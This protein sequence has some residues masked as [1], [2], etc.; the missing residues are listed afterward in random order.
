MSFEAL[1][2]KVKQAETAL[3]AQERQAAADW[4]Q[5]KASG[6]A[7]GRRAASSSPGWS[8]G[9]LVGRSNRRK[10]AAQRRRPLQL[11]STLAGL[12]A[13]GSAQAAA[14]EA[15]QAADTAQQTAAAVAP[16]AAHRPPPRDPQP[17]HDAESL[18]EA[19][20]VTTSS[21][22]SA[23][24]AGEPSPD[25]AD[26]SHAAARRRPTTAA[27]ATASARVGRVAGAGHARGRLHAVGRAGPDPAGAAGDVLRA[28]RQPDHPPAAAAV[29]AALRRR[30]AGAGAA[31]SSGTV[32]LGSNWSTPAGEWV[33]QVPRADARPRAE[34]ARAGQA[35]AGRQPGR[36][37]HRPRRR[38]RNRAQ[39]VQVV[40]HRG[41]RSLQGADVDAALARL[42]AGGGAADVLLH[43][44]R[45]KACSATRS[46]CCPG[47]SRSGSRSR[48]CSRSS[49][50]S[51]ATC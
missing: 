35:D 15:E 18:R 3:E 47:A 14:G 49:T 34:A 26:L 50:S 27:R 41:Q 36:R 46:R 11:V 16:E 51:R 45:R 8:S 42:G 28:G 29:G 33:R 37:E 48:S 24:D 21:H 17:T 2:N 23:D 30:A 9:F 39:P 4:R 43:G 7:A 19:G 31:A 38:R 40:K 6:S 10:R 5:F 25:A 13:G 22:E 20:P 32:L 1:L 44:L 12:F